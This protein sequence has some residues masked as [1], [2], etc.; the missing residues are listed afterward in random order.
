MTPPPSVERSGA[1]IDTSKI[2]YGALLFS[3]IFVAFMSTALIALEGRTLG[4]VFIAVPIIGIL[5][6]ATGILRPKRIQLNEERLTYRPVWGRTLVLRR[7]DI[8]SFDIF[9]LHYPG[10]GFLICKMRPEVLKGGSRYN[11]G[12]V[13]MPDELVRT[14]RR[15]LGHTP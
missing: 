5:F 6:S 2:V 15:W 3:W 10:S 14:L 8:A 4:S 12:F 7:A 13:M 1:V 9:L 11:L